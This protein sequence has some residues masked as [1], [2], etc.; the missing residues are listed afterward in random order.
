MLIKGHGMQFAKPCLD[1][2]ELVRGSNRCPK[3]EAANKTKRNARLETYE[4][5][6]RKRRKY[7]SEYRKRAKLVRE[8]GTHC[9]ICGQPFQAGDR[10]E[11]DHLFPELNNASPL[12][13]AHRRCNAKR[14]N[15]PIN[16]G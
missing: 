3:H 11:A 10:I 14:G 9:H 13:P 16:K 6:E 12:L 15:K 7:N 5:Q 8:R 1:C 4:R 2:G